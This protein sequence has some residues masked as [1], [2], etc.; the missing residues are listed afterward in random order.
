[1]SLQELATFLGW[2]TVINSA[3]LIVAAVSVIAMGG[4]MAK[5][6]SS[7][8][9]LSESELSRIYFK[10]IA[11]YKIAIFMLNLVPYIAVKA[12]L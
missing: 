2:C 3:F 11:Y 9:G 12:M 7:M 4:T 8:F 1:M 10:Y 6:H 5:M